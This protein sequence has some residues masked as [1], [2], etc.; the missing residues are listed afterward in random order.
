LHARAGDDG[1]L[2]VA[3][4]HDVAGVTQDRGN[5]GRDEELVLAEADHDR[6]AV[7][8]GDDLLGVFHRHEHDRKHPAQ[9]RECAAHGVLEPVVPHLALDEVERRSPYRSRS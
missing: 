8:Y 1:H 6:W 2:L 9:V 3:E 4:E 5:I 7:P